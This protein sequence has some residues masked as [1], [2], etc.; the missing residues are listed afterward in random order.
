MVVDPTMARDVVE[1]SRKHSIDKNNQKIW[2]FDE[3]IKHT[4]K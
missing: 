1:E 2:S 3:Q 4:Q